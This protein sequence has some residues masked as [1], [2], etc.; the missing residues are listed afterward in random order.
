MAIVVFFY[1]RF[2]M[3]CGRTVPLSACIKEKAPVS[4]PAL[5]VISNILIHLAGNKQ[6][7]LVKQASEASCR[8]L[9]I[10]VHFRT[11]LANAT[12]RVQYR[13]PSLYSHALHSLLLI[14]LGFTDQLLQ[15]LRLQLLTLRRCILAMCTGTS[16]A[17]LG[18]QRHRIAWLGL[19]WLDAKTQFLPRSQSLVG[20]RILLASAGIMTASRYST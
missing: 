11:F 8:S 3:C 5:F 15:Q 10:S 14:F 19:R 2:R 12:G 16:G 17:L 4:L 1:R 7:V 18:S 20:H 6:W 13:V 9:R